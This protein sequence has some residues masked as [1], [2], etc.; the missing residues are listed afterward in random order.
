MYGKTCLLL[1]RI[2]IICQIHRSR[3]K[4]EASHFF[5]ASLNLLR[6]LLKFGIIFVGSGKVGWPLIVAIIGV[7]D[8]I[9][10]GE[11]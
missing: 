3:N 8:I 7:V 6:Q 1:N 11:G 10:A 9:G 4:A 2:D 5:R